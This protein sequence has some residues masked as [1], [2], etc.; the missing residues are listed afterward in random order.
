MNTIKVNS[1]NTLMIAHRGMSGI[2]LE[3]TNAAFIAAGNRSHFGIETDVHKTADGKY[4][5]IHDDNTGRVATE[6][7][8]VEGSNFDTLRNLT[9]I[10]K[11]DSTRK[12]LCLP[13]LKEYVNTCKRY[14]KVGVLELKNEFTYEEIGEIIGEIK[15]CDYIE[16]II[17]ISFCFDNLVRV[18][19]YLPCSVVQFL[20][21]DFTQDLPD[22]LVEQK[23]DLDIHYKAL[24][25]ENID[26][27][28]SKGIKINCWTVD[29]AEEGQQLIDWGVDYVTS[30]ILE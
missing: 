3:N 11:G 18:R 1:K 24:T 13:T 6:D 20:V 14:E 2:E 10:H 26:L 5:I 15:E 16:N 7:I 30:N 9:L 25:K 12:E 23:F 17:F 29:T 8:S 22:R 21:D 4:I 19:Q 27:L 28:H